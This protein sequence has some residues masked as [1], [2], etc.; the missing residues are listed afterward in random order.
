MQT[1]LCLCLNEILHSVTNTGKEFRHTLQKL[2]LRFSLRIAEKFKLGDFSL[3]LESLI[4]PNMSP[5]KLKIETT[6]F[7]K[8][9]IWIPLVIAHS[10]K[11]IDN[12]AIYLSTGGG[13]GGPILIITNA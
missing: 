11:Q 7:T 12:V 8:N 6:I 2:S 5:L 9:G 13:G 1:Q 4:F 10:V 3:F